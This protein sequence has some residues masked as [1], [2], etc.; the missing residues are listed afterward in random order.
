VSPGGLPFEQHEEFGPREMTE[1]AQALGVVRGRGLHQRVGAVERGVSHPSPP[2]RGARS[3]GRSSSPNQGFRLSHAV[4]RQDGCGK[5]KTAGAWSR[6]ARTVSVTPSCV[7]EVPALRMA[8]DETER[9]MPG[10][11]A[12]TSCRQ[13][14]AQR[15]G[16][17][18][19]EPFAS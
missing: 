12:I 9:R 1:E 19:S 17:G 10:S 18:R 3:A 14:R 5:G 13:V 8:A 15:G 2:G 6:Q 7:T 16:G 4:F 11:A